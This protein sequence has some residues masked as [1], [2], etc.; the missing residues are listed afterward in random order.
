V[1][2]IMVST[3][4]RPR[5]DWQTPRCR[6][7]LPILVALAPI[8]LSGCAAPSPPEAEAQIAPGLR[9]AIPAPSEL[10]YN[11]DAVQLVTAH[12]RG[13][14]QTF[15]AHLSVA[16]QRLTLIGFDPFG[17]RAFTITAANGATRFEAAAG[18]PEGLR[19]GNILA[20]IAIV[21]WPASSVERGLP[22][23][24]ELQASGEGRSI[25]VGGREIIR[26]H[27]DTPPARGWPR[28][29][30]YSNDAFGYALDL[31]ST[32]TTP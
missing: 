5:A 14:I 1:V 22:A 7:V 12:Y 10:G 2:R 21:Y 16:P 30:H 4:W 19:P 11:I 27:Y 29:A 32:V 17:R 3:P 31:R 25:V 13:E 15:E 6:L 24:A 9:F 28:L 20:D 26:V 18:L 8:A 23:A